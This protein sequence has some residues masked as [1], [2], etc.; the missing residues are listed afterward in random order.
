MIFFKFFSISAVIP[1]TAVTEKVLSVFVC[2]FRLVSRMLICIGFVLPMRALFFYDVLQRHSTS[3]N[4]GLYVNQFGPITTD[5]RVVIGLAQSAAVCVASLLSE[6]HNL[7][8]GG[9]R[10]HGGCLFCFYFQLLR[11]YGEMP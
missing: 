10:H 2:W 9:C 6:V 5:L 7:I 11:I 4:S 1:S 3:Y 8:V